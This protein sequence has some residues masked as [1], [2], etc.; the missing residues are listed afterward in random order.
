MV[1]VVPDLDVVGVII[2]VNGLL[3]ILVVDVVGLLLGGIR[4]VV[5]GFISVTMPAPFRRSNRVCMLAF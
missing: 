2:T 5:S 4:G 1:V 3:A